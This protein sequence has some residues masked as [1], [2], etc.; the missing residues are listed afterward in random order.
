[1]IYFDMCVLREKI[2]LH[3]DDF[4]DFNL[5]HFYLLLFRFLF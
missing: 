4:D 3:I 2:V 5:N 1:M